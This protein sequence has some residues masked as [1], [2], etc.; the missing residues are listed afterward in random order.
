MAQKLIT[1][2]LVASVAWIGTAFADTRPDLTIAVT[3][4]ARHIDQLGPNASVN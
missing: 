1:I 4:L 2:A 3:K